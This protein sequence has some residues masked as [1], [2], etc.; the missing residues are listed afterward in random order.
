[1]DVSSQAVVYAVFEVP[2]D[3][4]DL[5]RNTLPRRAG[6]DVVR[7]KHSVTVFF[8]IYLNTVLAQGSQTLHTDSA[9]ML[10]IAL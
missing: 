2:T 9:T 4:C 7:E 5:C 10:P 1:M 6:R 3:S 8:G